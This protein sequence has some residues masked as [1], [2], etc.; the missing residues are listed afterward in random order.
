MCLFKT[1]SVWQFLAFFFAFFLD[2][3]HVLCTIHAHQRRMIKKKKKKPGPGSKLIA[4]FYI[5][6]GDNHAQILI[7]TNK[8]ALA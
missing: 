5:S 8:L 4:H 6:G 2:M 1:R 3:I 7:S